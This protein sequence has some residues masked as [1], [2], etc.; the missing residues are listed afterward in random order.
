MLP[1]EDETA[2]YRF[3]AVAVPFCGLVQPLRR[4]VSRTV[5]GFS[6]GSDD[7]SMVVRISPVWPDFTDT[8]SFFIVRSELSDA[9]KAFT[10]AEMAA[11]QVYPRPAAGVTG[12][13][14]SNSPAVSF[15]V[16]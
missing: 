7:S 10:V 3:F 11:P 14:K 1:E 12:K 2:V 9:T 4:T 15:R 8:V 13:K 16:G 5:S 6:A